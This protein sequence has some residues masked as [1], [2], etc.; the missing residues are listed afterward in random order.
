MDFYVQKARETVS[1]LQ[2]NEKAGQ[3]IFNYETD[4]KKLADIHGAVSFEQEA[5]FAMQL[6]KA[7]DYLC[8]VAVSNPDS[9]K[10]AILNVASIGLSLS[11]VYK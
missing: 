8:G 9:L 5:S 7:S 10:T 6:L 11:P 3:L 4:F 2:K 1:N